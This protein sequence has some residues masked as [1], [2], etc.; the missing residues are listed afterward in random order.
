MI[1]LI[2]VKLMMMVKEMLCGT[3]CILKNGVIFH[4]KMYNHFMKNLWLSRN[5]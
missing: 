5:F 1:K 3:W 2:Y 4:P